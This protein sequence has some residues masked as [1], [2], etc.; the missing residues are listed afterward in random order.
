MNAFHHSL[1][2]QRRQSDNFVRQELGACS[3]F[4][5]LSYA[6]TWASVFD[7]SRASSEQ[8]WAVLWWLQQI[9]YLFNGVLSLIVQWWLKRTMV[10]QFDAIFEAVRSALSR[11][12][13]LRDGAPYQSI[14]R[15][16]N[17]CRRMSYMVPSIIS[18]WLLWHQNPIGWYRCCSMETNFPPVHHGKKKPRHSRPLYCSTPRALRSLLAMFKVNGSLVGSTICRCSPLGGRQCQTLFLLGTVARLTRQLYRH[19]NCGPYEIV[20]LQ[21]GSIFLHTCTHT[22][23]HVHNVS[24]SIR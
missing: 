6:Y 5:Q 9:C 18:H 7:T 2:L 23:A 12:C 13:K 15:R 1:W 21:I 17:L 14:Q 22:R 20:W 24:L 19:G 8:G 11:S 10:T 16:P 3:A 4:S